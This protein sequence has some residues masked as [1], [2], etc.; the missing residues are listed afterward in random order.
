MIEKVATVSDSGFLR[1]LPSVAS[2]FVKAEVR[3][4]DYHDKEK[5]LEWLTSR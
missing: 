2:H 1:I 3:H 5:A 4:F